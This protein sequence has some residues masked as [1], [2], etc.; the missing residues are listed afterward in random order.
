MFD[1][2]IADV[3]AVLGADAAGPGAGVYGVLV[4]DAGGGL[5]V[6]G[7]VVTSVD[8]EVVAVGAGLNAGA[9]LAF[10]NVN[11]AGGVVLLVVLVYLDA[12]LCEVGTRGSGDG[13]SLDEG[14]SR[15]MSEEWV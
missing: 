11:G 4:D 13:M 14:G 3:S 7:A 1:S 8:G 15:W 12:G 5:L 2:G 6:D 9:V 10:G